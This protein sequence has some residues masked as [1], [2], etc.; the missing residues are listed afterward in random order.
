MLIYS[1]FYVVHQKR[2]FLVSYFMFRLYTFYEKT[3]LKIWKPGYTPWPIRRLCI[4]FLRLNNYTRVQLYFCHITSCYYFQ[5]KALF[6]KYTCLFSVLICEDPP[7]VSHASYQNRQRWLNGSTVIYTCDTGY[8]IAEG[9]GNNITCNVIGAG[10]QWSNETV[11]CI[12]S[13]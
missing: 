7:A 10:V 12:P 1:S 3:D 5:C 8:E 13:M 4:H 9:S 11:N 6:C 2:I